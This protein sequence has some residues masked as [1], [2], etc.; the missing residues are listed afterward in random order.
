MLRPAAVQALDFMRHSLPAYFCKVVRLAQ[1]VSLGL[2]ACGDPFSDRLSAETEIAADAGSEEWQL[3][4]A[5][6]F[7]DR[8]R[9]NLQIGGYLLDRHD[10]ARRGSGGFHHLWVSTAA[11]LLRYR[12]SDQNRTLAALS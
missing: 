7:V 1:S 11:S 6:E 3:A 9:M 12:R 4:L 8:A 2:L 5:N 10:R